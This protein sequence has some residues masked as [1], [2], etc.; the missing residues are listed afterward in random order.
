MRLNIIRTALLLAAFCGSLP[1]PIMAQ[2]GNHGPVVVELFTSQGC[3]SCPPADAFLAGLADRDDVIALA[4]HVDYWDYIGW[5]DNFG[6]AAFTAR[7]KAYALTN[8]TRSVYTPQMVVEG[9]A[10]FAG[11]RPMEVVNAILD[12]REE[13]EPAVLNLG[14]TGD[15][16]SVALAPRPQAT[17]A[18]PADVYLVR[19]KPEETVSIERGENAGK[20]FAYHNIVTEWQTLAAWDGSAPLSLTAK[21][22]GDQPIVVIVQA[23]NNGPILTAGIL[24]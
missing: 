20:T 17:K 18:T 14:R 23:G 24:H 12:A 22:S 10:F 2:T 13:V 7:Q 16:L 9:R 4:L 5:P 6:S 8:G 21:V 11:P 1:A 15:E 19:Y 3:S